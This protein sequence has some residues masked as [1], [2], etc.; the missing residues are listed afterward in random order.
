[1]ECATAPT[2]VVGSVQ[3][4]VAGEMAVDALGKAD[5]AEVSEQRSGICATGKRYSY[6]ET[7][8]MGSWTLLPPR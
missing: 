3:E 8:S 7:C 1:M 6:G 5:N 2:S 4:A